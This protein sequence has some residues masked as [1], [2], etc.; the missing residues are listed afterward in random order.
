MAELTPLNILENSPRMDLET[1]FR[2]RCGPDRDCFNRCCSDV[3][4]LLSPYDILRL[5]NGLKIDSSEFLEKYTLTMSSKDKRIPAVFLRMDEQTRKCPFV[6]DS[7]CQVYPN[8][9]WACRMYPL[10]MAEPADHKS[11]Q[12]RF[13]FRVEEE[14][15]HGHGDGEEHSVREWIESQ[16]LE[17]FDQM[18]APFLELMAH[19]DWEKPE[20]VTD[21]KLAMFYMA[22]FDL[23]R[24]RRFISETRFL[25]L[26]E[27]D[28]SRIQAIAE[29]DEELLD[30]AIDWIAFSLFQEKRM[31]LRKGVGN[32]AT[33]AQ[34]RKPGSVQP[35]V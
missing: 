22:M 32:G 30:F 12:Q 2:F 23:D 34:T 27:I 20:T 31:K 21:Q 10:G 33:E 8:R 7:G 14:L 11:A 17:S 16:H 13:Y 15:C 35:A 26:F 5:K 6:G 19:P 4:I 3:A 24:F 29:D 1:K 25:D 9:P 18:Q 28:E